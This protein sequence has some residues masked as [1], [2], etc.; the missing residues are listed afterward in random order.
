MKQIALLICV[1]I[2]H[3]SF[4]Q[5]VGVGTSNIEPTAKLQVEATN[6][7]M[8]TPRLTT[9]QRNAISNPAEGLIIYNLTTHCLEF[10]NG[11][12]WIS[13]CNSQ[14]PAV[15]GRSCKS[16]KLANPSATDGVYV[17]DPD[18][19]GIL[20]SMSCY[21][22]M[23][24]DGG[25][26][27]LVLNYLHQGGTNP[28]L[29]V[30]SNSLPLLGSTILGTDE[31]ATIYWGH[32]ANSLLNGFCFNEIRFYGK[33]SNHSRIIHFKTNNSNTISY[34]RT[35]TGNC[36]GINLGFTTLTGHTANLPNATANYYSN[37]G[38]LAMTNFPFWLAYTYHWGIKGS[39]PDRWEVDDNF[40]AWVNGY[41]YNTHHQIWIR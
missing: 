15:C 26:W 39:P 8:L 25:G 21:C 7:G 32:S 3:L 28:N 27:T 38:N 14:T 2:G 36:T 34:F 9:A 37:A 18:S 41:F 13:N 1:F 31:S 23:T 17:V 5:S 16:I 10:Y 24:T 20:P 30:R 35:G 22:D 29:N 12:Q 6:Q 19:N 11:S 33:T 4:S 40:S